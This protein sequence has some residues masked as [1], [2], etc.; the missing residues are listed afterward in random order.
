MART[1]TVNRTMV[2]IEMFG[3]GDSSR[4]Y[5]FIAD[6]VDGVA[7]AVDRC[8]GYEV[9]NLGSKHPITLTEMIETVEDACEVKAVVLKKPMQ[10]G[11]VDRTADVRP[12]PH[13]HHPEHDEVRDVHRHVQQEHGDQQLTRPREQPRHRRVPPWRHTTQ[14]LPVGVGQ[15]E[16]RRK[17]RP[18]VF[19][20]QQCQ[21]AQ[22]A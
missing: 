20:D 11:D 14:P 2:A 4:D 18:D 9:I 16:Q 3:L 1:P 5:T 12:R 13:R 6:I 22:S 19:A 15:P 8:R 10:P 7:R 21:R 17:F